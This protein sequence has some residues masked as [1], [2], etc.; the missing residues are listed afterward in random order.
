MT[1]LIGFRTKTANAPQGP[2]AEIRPAPAIADA[3]GVAVVDTSLSAADYA[4]RI[5]ALT[6]GLAFLAT[7]V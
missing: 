1:P 4:Y 2:L 6:A 3:T 7:F 5:A